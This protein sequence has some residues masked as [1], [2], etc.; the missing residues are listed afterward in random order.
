MTENTTQTIGVAQ[1]AGNQPSDDQKRLLARIKR[2]VR[3]NT[4]GGVQKLVVEMHLE[5]VRLSGRCS[6][7][8][9]KQVAQQ[10]AMSLLSEA[11]QLLNEIEV[12]S[13]PR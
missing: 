12:T 3:R 2:A 6:S 13:L 10:T 8:Y 7:F 11:T 5:G 4:S 1:V 9:C